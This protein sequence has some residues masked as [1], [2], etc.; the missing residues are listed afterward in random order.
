VAVVI[1]SDEM[2]VYLGSAMGFG[3]WTLIDPVG[4]PSACIFEDEADARDFVSTWDDQTGAEAFRYVPV[5]TGGA[6]CAEIPVLKAA[7]LGHLLG[8]MEADA[9][10]YAEPAG[11]A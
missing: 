11:T 3:F 4:Q 5:E 8:D 6:K 10:R 1:V 2:G 9:L 7:G